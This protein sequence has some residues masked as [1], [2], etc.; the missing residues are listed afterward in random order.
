[1]DTL[2][3]K[4]PR[5]R[6]S[7]HLTVLKGYAMRVIAQGEALSSDEE[8]DKEIRFREF[9]QIG[10][11]FTLSE[12]EMVCLMFKGIISST[13]NPECSCTDCRLESPEERWE[14]R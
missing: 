14:G 2:S 8:D 10:D 3:A 6:M 11:S 13:S 5:Q 12:R 4:D 1:M 9:A 7:E